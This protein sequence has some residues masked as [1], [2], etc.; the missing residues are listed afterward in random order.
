V[1]GMIAKGMPTPISLAMKVAQKAMLSSITANQIGDIV[2]AVMGGH[3]IGA[4]SALGSGGNDPGSANADATAA[5][6]DALGLTGPALSGLA[7]AAAAASQSGRGEASGGGSSSGGNV[8]A[9]IGV[10]GIGSG[11]VDGSGEGIGG[12]TGG[13]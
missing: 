4:M 1:L 6:M 13:Y 7:A 8:G 12:A 5:A 11:G 2:G 10:G 3:N 9:G